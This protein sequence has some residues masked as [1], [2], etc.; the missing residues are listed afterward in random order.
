MELMTTIALVKGI[1]DETY[2]SLKSYVDQFCQGKVMS[3]QFSGQRYLYLHDPQDVAKVQ[4]Q[5][6]SLIAFQKEAI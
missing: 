4:K 6:G 3:V 5:F 1:S 2:R